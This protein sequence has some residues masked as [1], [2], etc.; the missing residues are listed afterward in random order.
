[1]SS[2]ADSG[3]P[4]QPGPDLPLFRAVQHLVCREKAQNTHRFVHRHARTREN[5]GSR[6]SEL[7]QTRPGQTSR[8]TEV[9][10]HEQVHRGHRGRAPLSRFPRP[11]SRRAA[12]PSFAPIIKRVSPAVVNIART[13]HGRR[14]AQSVLRRSGLPPLLRP[15]AGRA[16]ARPRIQERGLRRH[17]RREERLHRHERPCRQERERDHDHA[18][19]RRRAQGRGR[20]RRRA[21]G[22]RGAAGQGREAAGR[23]APRRLLAS[24]RSATS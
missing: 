22:R 18:G 12:L 4:R 1:M 6:A 24:S 8:P 2:Q 7:V 21:L 13:R 10:F 23:D 14:A 5:Q 3:R 16:A 17:R 9:R 20:G 15:A 19:G 11:F